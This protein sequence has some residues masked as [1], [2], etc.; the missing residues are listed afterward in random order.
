MKK[1]FLMLALSLSVV[2]MAGLVG[3]DSKPKQDA[4]PAAEAA[5][6]AEAEAAKPAAEAAKPAEAE[7]AKPDAENK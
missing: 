7:A 3:C 1:L 5:K 4:K 6:P 2:A